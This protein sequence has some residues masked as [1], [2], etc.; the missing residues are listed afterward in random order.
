MTRWKLVHEEYFMETRSGYRCR[1]WRFNEKKRFYW[2]V[3]Q[4]PGGRKAGNEKTL[5]KAK[6]AVEAA[7][8]KLTLKAPEE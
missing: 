6:L 4:R 7:L 3:G 1:I 2:K 5:A 8:N